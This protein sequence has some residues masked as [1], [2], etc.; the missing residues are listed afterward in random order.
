[1]PPPR[2]ITVAFAFLLGS[3]ATGRSNDGLTLEWH[4]L[5][6]GLSRLV[7]IAKDE[8]VTICMDWSQ[9]S[10]PAPMAPTDTFYSHSMESGPMVLRPFCSIEV[11]DEH[12][13]RVRRSP[14][15]G[16][17][18]LEVQRRPPHHVLQLAP[19]DRLSLD[20]TYRDK[21]FRVVVRLVI[22]EGGGWKEVI[23]ETKSMQTSRHRNHEGEQ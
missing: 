4:P 12:G 8:P 16:R 23:L 22:F 2:L 1:M 17:S 19:G 9:G 11:Y 14:F 21:P 20:R 15:D 7:L 10:K 6:N 5:S 13:E 3:L 18:L